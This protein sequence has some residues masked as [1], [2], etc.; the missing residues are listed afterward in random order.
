[1]YQGFR[2]RRVRIITGA[3]LFSSLLFAACGADNSSKSSSAGTTAAPAPTSAATTATTAAA[4]TTTV[5]AATTAAAIK[6]DK[7]PV[8]I[9]ALVDLSG[10]SK[11]DRP[12]LAKALPA[13]ANYINA[14]GGLNGHPVR[15]EIRDTVSDAAKAQ[16]QLDELV[17]LKPIA[18]YIDSSAT[19]SAQA[20]ALGK[21]G[22]PILGS[23]Y[24]PALWGAK[25][26]SL[27]ANCDPSGKP[28]PCA[29]PNAFTVTTTFGAV[30]DQAVV[31]AKALGAKKIVNVVC[32]EIDSCSSSHPEFEATGKALGYESVPLVKVSS[33][34]ANYTSECVQFIQDGVDYVNM[35]VQSP[36]IVQMWQDCQ[37]Q[38]Y[39]GWFGALTGSFGGPTLKAP[40]IRLG[41]GIQAF[42]WF[43]D[44][45]L[46]KEF[47]A[48]MAA[49]GLQEGDLTA[50]ASAMWSVLQLFAKAQANL[51][52][53]P[54]GAEALENMYTIKDET[55]GGL[56]P[57]ITFTKG[58][59]A[60]PRDC[61]YPVN[62]VDGKLTAP[63]GG[64]QFDCYPSKN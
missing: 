38:G 29:Q 7:S 1:M 31:E 57:P 36:V 17:N 14:K 30:L 42:P 15:F 52:D 9:G 26:T 8:V 18:I 51:S 45:P 20:Q 48:A 28:L 6:A 35:S 27:G 60:Q 2:T 56:I 62:F 54:T 49:G 53:Q 23:G 61:F 10:P 25:L 24:S 22:I 46:V 5:A 19:E 39:K 59:P 50:T 37:D 34:A 44:D 33:T 21:T 4:A 11:G 43:V 16:T 13:W 40:D 55:L 41:G 63:L 58:Q 64:L 32:A 12:L 3:V 47:R